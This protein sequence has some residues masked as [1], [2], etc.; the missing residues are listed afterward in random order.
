MKV[1]YFRKPGL[2]LMVPVIHCAILR[3]SVGEGDRVISI[4]L[5]IKFLHPQLFLKLF[6]GLIPTTHLKETLGELLK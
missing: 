1:P 4:S 5:G 2:L 3:V 6:V